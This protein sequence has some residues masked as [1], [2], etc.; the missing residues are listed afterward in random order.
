[1]LCTLDIH[2]Q[3]THGLAIK[4]PHVISQ[5]ITQAFMVTDIN[6]SVQGSSGNMS[7][8]KKGKLCMK[9]WQ[10]DGRKRVQCYCLGS[11]VQKLVKI[12]TP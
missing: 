8:S 9:L 1:M 3:K 11:I 6:K 7:V 10:V 5:T 12:C 2:S 4:V